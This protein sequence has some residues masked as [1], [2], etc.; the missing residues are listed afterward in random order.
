[1]RFAAAVWFGVTVT[2]RSCLHIRAS[3]EKEGVS[4]LVIDRRKQ[5]QYSHVAIETCATTL[6]R[7][8]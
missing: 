6:R 2:Q 7:Q 8:W 3:E 5:C 4:Y 1:M